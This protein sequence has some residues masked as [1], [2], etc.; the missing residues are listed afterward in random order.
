MKRNIYNPVLLFSQQDKIRKAFPHPHKGIRIK[1]R[2]VCVAKEGD[3]FTFKFTYAKGWRKAVMYV[4][5]SEE[6]LAAMV[7]LASEINNEEYAKG[8]QK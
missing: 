1:N 6:A 4:P 7:Q 8:L 3:V 5:I 2:K